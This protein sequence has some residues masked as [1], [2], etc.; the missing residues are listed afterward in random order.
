MNNQFKFQNIMRLGNGIDRKLRSI[1]QLHHNINY[2]ILGCQ[3]SMI[4][5]LNNGLLT[6]END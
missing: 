5:F 3:E 4:R 2:I 6:T 1:M